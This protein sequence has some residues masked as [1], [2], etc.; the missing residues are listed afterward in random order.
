VSLGVDFRVSEAQARP[1]V[2]LSLFLLPV[3]PD[4]ELSATCPACCHASC[5]DNNRPN[6]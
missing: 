6:L 4:V 3:D 5:H 2:S 1:S